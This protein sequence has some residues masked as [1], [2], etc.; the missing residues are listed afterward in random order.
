MR[1]ECTP[2]ELSAAPAD[3]AERK[4]CFD[5]L[6]Q[7]KLRA[8]LSEEAKQ[9]QREKRAAEQRARRAA[10]SEEAKQAQ[11]E[12]NAAAARKRC[13]ALRVEPQQAR[14]ALQDQAGQAADGTVASARHKRQ[15]EDVEPVAQPACEQLVAAQKRQGLQNAANLSEDVKAAE[16]EKRNARERERRAALSEEAKAGAA[17]ERG[18]RSQLVC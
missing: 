17:R 3:P 10:L 15:R 11:R 16:R 9:A 5:R 7:R 14:S 8:K 18:A 4:Q 6:R 1:S 13:A 12:K 2:E